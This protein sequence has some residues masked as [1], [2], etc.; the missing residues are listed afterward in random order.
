AATFGPVTALRP[1]PFE[2]VA[3]GR[4]LTEPRVDATGRWLAYV[5][6]DTDGSRFV[7]VDLD[8]EATTRRVAPDPAPL[9]GRGMGGGSFCWVPGAAAIVYAAAD[10]V[11]VCSLADETL[12]C[13]WPGEAAQAPAVSPD[14]RHVAFMVDQRQIVVAP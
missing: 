13:V 8:G 14:G 12:R 9:P 6:S 5:E 2:L 7:I 3:A 10:G 11:W 4:Q 1:I